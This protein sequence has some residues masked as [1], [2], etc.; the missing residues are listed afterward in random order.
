MSAKQH[1]RQL[2]L[3]AV[4]ATLVVAGLATIVFGDLWVGVAAIAL[5]AIAA[6]S[7][8]QRSPQPAHG[9]RR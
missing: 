7:A 5:G 3:A 1:N 2:L 9:L 4:T 6:L 8:A